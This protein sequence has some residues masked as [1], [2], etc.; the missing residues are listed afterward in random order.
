MSDEFDDAFD[1]RGLRGRL[2][3]RSA[4]DGVRRPE[5]PRLMSR[6][7]RTAAEPLRARMLRCLIRPLHSRRRLDV[8]RSTGKL[9]KQG[10][11]CER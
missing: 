7:Y 5:V 3:P 2:I 6:L 4:V 10:P 9:Q 11:R 8:R 1:D